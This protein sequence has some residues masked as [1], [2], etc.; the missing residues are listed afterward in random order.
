MNRAGSLSFTMAPGH[1]L[2]GTIFPLGVTI[3][4]CIDSVYDDVEH[5]YTGGRAVWY[6]RIITI[7]RTFNLEKNITC[8]GALAFLNDVMVRPRKYFIASGEHENMPYEMSAIKLLQE[9]YN[10]YNAIV[11]TK[12]YKRQFNSIN[13]VTPYD[14]TDPDAY[15][16]YINYVTYS[17]VDDYVTFFD[18]FSE[19]A[20]TD[21]KVGIWAEYN[22]DQS[23]DGLTLFIAYLPW[24]ESVKRIEFANNLVDYT[25]NGDGLDIYNA[26]IPLGANKIR[27]S[28]DCEWHAPSGENYKAYMATSDVMAS[29]TQG[30][31]GY[32]E[33]TI[34]YN[35]CTDRDTLYAVAQAN[36]TAYEKRQACEFNITAVELAWL[37]EDR[38][39]GYTPI[40]LADMFT[41]DHSDPQ[42][43]FNPNNFLD[44]GWGAYFK[45]GVHGE[46]RTSDEFVC[47]SLSMD[48]DNPGATQ[49]RFQVYDS[50]FAPT[51]PKM[52]TEYYDRKKAKESGILQEVAQNGTTYYRMVEPNRVKKIDDNHVVAD[53][54]DHEE[55][56][57]AN[58]TGDERTDIEKTD[59]AK[60]TTPF[61]DTDNN[62]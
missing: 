59:M 10:E 41:P 37:S 31:Y 44:I 25:N 47:I 3:K 26:V 45:S 18:K 60:G 29:V 9:L 55:H 19:I 56:Y 32:I 13:I 2:Y 12:A 5:T 24:S 6:G 15:N 48:L 38:D 8:E 21:P 4:V 14:P 7:E 27:L 36:L 49:Y 53:Y 46:E 61:D 43:Q 57:T 1:P 42:P 28:E 33:K 20:G 23:D 35:D 50:Y 17:G 30:N 40:I 16:G 52:L 62:S 58:G 11:S 51:S 34:D 39:N 54:P 22:D